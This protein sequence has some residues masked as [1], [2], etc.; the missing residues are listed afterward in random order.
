MPNN[1]SW[2]NLTNMLWVEYP[3]GTGFTQGKPVATNEDEAAKDF[4]GFFRNFVDLF[5]LQNRKIYITGESYAGYYVPYIANHMLDANNT[6]YYNVH[7]IQIND[8][9]TT[10]DVMQTDSKWHTPGSLRSA[11]SES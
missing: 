5:G 6:D 8:P 3:I 9:S 4:L 11:P 7:G 10:Y 1:W 2:T